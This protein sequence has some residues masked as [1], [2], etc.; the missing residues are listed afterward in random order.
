L[1]P[2]DSAQSLGLGSAESEEP[3]ETVIEE[4]FLNL[5]LFRDQVNR[6][7]VTLDALRGATQASQSFRIGRDSLL[8][9]QHHMVVPGIRKPGQGSFERGRAGSVQLANELEH[10]HP[11]PIPDV[12]L[13]TFLSLSQLA[14][15]LLLQIVGGLSRGF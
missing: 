15:L 7:I 1:Q 4:E 10:G 5:S 9:V 8:N 14:S 2:L 12:Y 3:G 13:E 11:A 6:T